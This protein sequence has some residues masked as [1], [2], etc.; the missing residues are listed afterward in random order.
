MRENE[1]PFTV[2][3][4]LRGQWFWRTVKNVEGDVRLDRH[5]LDNKGDPAP[6]AT[7]IRA[8]MLVNGERLEVPMDGTMFWYCP[9]RHRNLELRFNKDANQKVF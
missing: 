4:K 2:K 3:Y 5:L 8:L 6:W 9:Q 1:K 7:P